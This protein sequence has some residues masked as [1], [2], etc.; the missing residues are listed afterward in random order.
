MFQPGTCMGQDALLAHNH[1]TH[2]VLQVPKVAGVNQK[3]T[4]APSWPALG[5]HA[6]RA[7]RKRHK[8]HA[9]IP[10]PGKLDAS[11]RTSRFFSRH[12]YDHKISSAFACDSAADIHRA[13]NRTGRASTK[14]RRTGPFCSTPEK[15]L[16]HLTLAMGNLMPQEAVQ[17]P[18]QLRCAHASCTRF[19]RAVVC[20]KFA[21]ANTR[22]RRNALLAYATP[23]CMPAKNPCDDL[24]AYQGVTCQAPSLGPDTTYWQNAKMQTAISTPTAARK[25]S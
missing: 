4:S 9:Q 22:L 24:P 25:L 1:V 10:F 8:R 23:V 12:K 14:N 20:A 5:L 17:W 7:R 15:A 16:Y 2:A 19:S 6:P 21:S 13:H 3:F 11:T 18:V